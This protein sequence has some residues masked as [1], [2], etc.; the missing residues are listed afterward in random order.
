MKEHLLPALT[1]VVALVP[2]ALNPSLLATEMTL[3]AIVCGSGVTVQI[4]LGDPVLPGT[5][6]SACCA[7]GCHSSERKKKSARN[8]G[9]DP[10]Q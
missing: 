3:G 10:Q 2:A 5:L 4:P 6:G 1:G 9:I 7:K 8:P